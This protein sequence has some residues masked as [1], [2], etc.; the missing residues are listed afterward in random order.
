MHTVADMKT[1]VVTPRKISPARHDGGDPFSGLLGTARA[2]GVF[3]IRSLF[4]PPWA[5]RVEDRSPLTLIAMLSGVAWVVPDD[6]EPVELR[7]GDVGIVRDFG[8]YT[9]A[10]DPDTA[11]SFLIEPGPTFRTIRRKP[12]PDDM[13][14]DV[15]TWGTN[16]SAAMGMV[17]ASYQMQS[18]LGR[19]LL[20]SLPDLVVV[21]GGKTSDVVDLLDRELS[22]GVPG[23]QALLDRLV[24]LLLVSQLRSWA[25]T[26]PG[27]PDWTVAYGDPF[28]GPALRALQDSPAE[29][30]TVARLA[31]YVGASRAT[32]ARRFTGLVGEPPMT[33]L[34]NWRLSL[35]A[36]LLIEDE[37]TVEAVARR[38]GYGSPYALSTAFKRQMGVSPSEHRNLA[39]AG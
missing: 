33:F 13:K 17:T 36:D 3:A 9:M 19:R 29:A 27:L 30:W 5:V 25:A 18:H 38:V 15:R 22:V 20:R 31:H 12:I 14:L 4:D 7:Q 21:R 10:H 28:V 23:Q 2:R 26:Q 16:P 35:A 34:T 39:R 6:D 8:A 11:P 37:M 32:L 1:Q 24:D